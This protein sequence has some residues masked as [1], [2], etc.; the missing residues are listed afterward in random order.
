MDRGGGGFLS[1]GGGMEGEG[2]VEGG[3][4]RRQNLNKHVHGG[5]RGGR[6][7][8]WSSLRETREEPNEQRKKTLNVLILLFFPQRDTL[9]C[10]GEKK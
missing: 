3:N 5:K 10:R 7:S 1:L 4:N 8:I 9:L 2:E 6:D